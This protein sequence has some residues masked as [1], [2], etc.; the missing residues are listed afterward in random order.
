MEESVQKR[1]LD[2]QNQA[3]RI[4]IEAFVRQVDENIQPLEM[5]VRDVAKSLE[6]IQKQV[7]DL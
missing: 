3:F 5:A 6:H 7:E 2:S 1:H 4:T